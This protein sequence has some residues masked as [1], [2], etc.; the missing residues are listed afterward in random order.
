MKTTLG[1]LATC[2]IFSFNVQAQIPAVGFTAGAVFAAYKAKDGYSSMTSDNKI[3]PTVGLVA[4]IPLSPVISFRPEIKYVQKGG[5]FTEGGYTD[6]VSFSYIEVP[7]DFVYN[8][9]GSGGSFFAGLGPSVNIGFSGKYTMGSETYD[10]SFGDNSNLKPLEISANILAG[11]KFENG[12]FV[13]VN[14]NTGLNNI[15]MDD[16][17]SDGKIYNRYFGINIGLMLQPK[18][19]PVPGK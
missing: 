13:S 15:V 11:Y 4:E 7:F 19:R 6:K 10:I 9:V 14:Y 8:T 12:F 18:V 2:V 5:D 16:Y 17:Q 3:G 1:I